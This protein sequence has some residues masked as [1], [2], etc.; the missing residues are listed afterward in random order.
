MFDLLVAGLNIDNRRLGGGV[1]VDIRIDVL[2]VR[3]VFRQVVIAAGDRGRVLLLL[4]EG[5]AHPHFDFLELPPPRHLPIIRFL[6]G[7][8]V[9]LLLFLGFL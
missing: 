9:R 1:L 3:G 2:D 5:L 6:L 7:H 8:E 4:Q